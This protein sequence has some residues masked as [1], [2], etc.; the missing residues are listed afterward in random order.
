MTTLRIQLD[1]E[2]YVKGA[3]AAAPSI[4]RV[5]RV[6]AV[7]MVAIVLAWM[8]GYE[9]QAFTGVFVLLFAIA[10]GV[11]GGRLSA[12]RTARRVSKQQKTL[13]RPYELTWDDEKV[14]TTSDAGNMT[15][16]WSELHKIHEDDRQFLLFMSDVMFV[17]VP[18]RAFPD[19]QSRAAFR[20]TINQNV[21]TNR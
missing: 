8:S 4:W 2:D 15:L 6:L 11:I 13:H 5:W 7:G 21:S 14:T 16:K 20:T 3:L 12:A 17:M 1:E 9:Q 18:K 19:D 10:G